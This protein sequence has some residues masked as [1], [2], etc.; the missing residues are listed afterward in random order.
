MRRPPPLSFTS[1]VLSEVSERC[2]EVRGGEG[3]IELRGSLS[4][5]SAGWELSASARWYRKVINVYVTARQVDERS[6]EAI[7]DHGYAATLEVPPGRYHLRLNHIYLFA[8]GHPPTSGLPMY[9]RG[10]WVK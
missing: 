7:E 10:V 4:A 1:A 3:R 6:G 9:E 8:T 2:F 5:G